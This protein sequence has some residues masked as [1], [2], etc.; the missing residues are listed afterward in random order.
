MHRSHATRLHTC[1]IRRVPKP[2][3]EVLGAC[4][5]HSAAR[6]PLQPVHAAAGPLQ[7]ALQRAVARIPAARAWR[8]RALRGAHTRTV[9]ALTK[10]A[11]CRPGRR[12]QAACRQR[13]A[14]FRMLSEKLQPRGA[15][16]LQRTRLKPTVA[17]ESAC[18]TSSVGANAPSGCSCGGRRVSHAHALAQRRGPTHVPQ[19]RLVVA[20]ASGK[21]RSRSTAV[22]RDGV[23]LRAACSL[24]RQRQRRA[25][26]ARAGPV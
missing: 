12:S 16:T 3:R 24:S 2:S 8:S 13:C 23:H 18:P 11:L 6:V 19:E 10:P 15:G 22:A 9:A 4:E 14:A 26:W 1:A 21:L 5:Q 7:A 25:Q 17:T 20:A